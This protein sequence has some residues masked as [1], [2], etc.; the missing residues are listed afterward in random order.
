MKKIFVVFISVLLICTLTLNSFASPV[1]QIEC[2]F[3]KPTNFVD[4]NNGYH[5]FYGLSDSSFSTP[6]IIELAVRRNGSSSV[7]RCTLSSTNNSLLWSFTNVGGTGTR[8]VDYTIYTKSGMVRYYGYLE[9][10]SS[11]FSISYEDLWF[12]DQPSLNLIKYVDPIG[13]S[14]DINVTYSFSGSRELAYDLFYFSATND[15]INFI[16]VLPEPVSDLYNSYVLIA[17]ELNCFLVCISSASPILNDIPIRFVADDRWLFQFVNTGNDTSATFLIT[18]FDATSGRY[19]TMSEVSVAANKIQEWGFTNSYADPISYPYCT[20][21]GCMLDNT[22]YDYPISRV[23]ITFNYNGSTDSLLM[24]IY[25]SIILFHRDIS[26]ELVNSLTQIISDF[27]LS[28]SFLSDLKSLLTDNVVLTQDI[29]DLLLDLISPEA[30][31]IPTFQEVPSSSLDDFQDSESKVYDVIG[32]D[33]ASE[34]DS[35]LNFDSNSNQLNSNAFGFIKGIL[36]GTVFYHNKL[37]SLI[38]FCLAMGIAVLILG[39]RLNV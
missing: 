21:Y 19:V 27:G 39:R 16:S 6:F 31:D 28:N 8:Y 26:Q 18:V 33:F 23:P 24:L 15:G 17:N 30:E 1:N 38:V 11:S 3:S 22:V 9:F 34:A 12:E 14:S 29:Y 32:T 5:Y 2:L 35:I 37:N 13:H 20:T 36:E 25:S 4:F 7:I 10:S